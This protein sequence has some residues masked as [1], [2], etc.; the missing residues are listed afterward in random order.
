MKTGGSMTK[1]LGRVARLISM[2]LT[3]WSAIPALI[4][5]L[6]SLAAAAEPTAAVHSGSEQLLPKHT[7]AFVRIPSAR[8]FR[9]KWNDSSFGTM[10]NDPKFRGFFADIE[11]QIAE[12][13]LGV[14]QTAGLSLKELW[15]SLEG[16]I[17]LAVVN[18]PEADWGLALV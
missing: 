14:Q 9:Q 3:T 11:R 1:S 15:L 12:L 2:R 13:T 18:R 6:S 8:T 17:S 7:L 10:Q 4:L 16:E 5:S